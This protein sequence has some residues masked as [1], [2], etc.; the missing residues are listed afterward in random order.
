MTTITESSK[1]LTARDRRS[2]FTLTELL[3]ATTLGSIVLAAVFSALIFVS[4]GT[5]NL[6]DYIS[7]DQEAQIAL[8]IFSRDARM[9]SNVSNYTTNGITLTVPTASSSYNVTYSYDPDQKI[10]WKAHGTPNQKALIKNIHRFSLKR[11]NLQQNLA[12]ND[13]ETKQ[14]QLDIESGRTGAITAK[15]TNNVLSARYILRNKSVSN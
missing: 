3:I 12:S 5:F 8:E 9:A 4:K 2:G 7:M 15:T 13:L 1:K 6:T 11:Y 14:L 10:F